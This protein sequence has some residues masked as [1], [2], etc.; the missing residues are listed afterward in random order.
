MYRR[1]NICTLS[2]L[3]VCSD[4]DISHS[5]S[6]GIDVTVDVYLEDDR[7]YEEIG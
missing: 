3:L 1:L 5:E 7:D 2:L 4:M 6:V